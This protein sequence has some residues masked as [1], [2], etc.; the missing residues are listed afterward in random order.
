MEKKITDGWLRQ[1]WRSAN[2]G[3]NFLL[4]AGLFGN[5]TV[6]EMNTNFTQNYL[7]KMMGLMTINSK[8]V[9]YLKEIIRICMIS[10]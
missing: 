10:L 3:D 8:Q 2:G 7:E 4:N 6:K 5:E 1:L 9:N